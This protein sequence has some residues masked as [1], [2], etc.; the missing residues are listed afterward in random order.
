MVDPIH[1]VAWPRCRP[2]QD[3]R[4]DHL[5]Q[6][7]ILG[8]HQQ[9]WT[10][11]SAANAAREMRWHRAH[12]GRHQDTVLGG[13]ELRNIGAG[14][15]W[16]SRFYGAQVVESRLAQPAARNDRMVQICI[17]KETDAH[18]FLSPIAWRAC[19]KLAHRSGL[20]WLNGIAEAWNARS[21]CSRY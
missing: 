20:A 15:S 8:Y 17:R 1:P 12:V 5:T 3:H 16:Q 18:D 14:H 19:S 7:G 10:L 2:S 6:R 4:V 11:L 9:P 13:S 21:L